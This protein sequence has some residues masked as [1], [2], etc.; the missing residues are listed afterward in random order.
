MVGLYI[1]ALSNLH[2]VTPG[3]KKTRVQVNNQ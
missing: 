1:E 3:D 2:T